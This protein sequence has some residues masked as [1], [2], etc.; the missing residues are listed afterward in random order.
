LGE[1]RDTEIDDPYRQSKAAYV[2]ALTE[3]DASVAD[4]VERLKN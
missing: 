2:E 4:W 1:W 3:I